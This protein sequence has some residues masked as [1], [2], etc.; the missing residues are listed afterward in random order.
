MALSQSLGRPL[1]PLLELL[2]QP[3]EDPLPTI[4]E[5]S[6]SDR[7]GV[8]SWRE[9]SL[10]LSPNHGG[11]LLVLPVLARYTHAVSSA[12]PLHSNLTTSDARI[13]VEQRHASSMCEVV[14]LTDAPM[15]VSAMNGHS[16]RTKIDKISMRKYI[17]GYTSEK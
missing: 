5:G 4:L 3:L 1:N 10:T 9:K 16:E 6:T 13:I 2:T 11:H 12:E 15:L 7:R 17:R 14:H 8:R